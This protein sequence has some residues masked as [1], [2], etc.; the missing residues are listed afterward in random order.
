[1]LDWFT[2]L[3]NQFPNANIANIFKKTTVK[4]IFLDKY[5]IMK[6]TGLQFFDVK[7]SELQAFVP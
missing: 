5:G 2:K 6:N 3:V 1:M 7:V 4:K